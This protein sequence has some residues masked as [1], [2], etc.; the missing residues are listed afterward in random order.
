MKYNWAMMIGFF[1]LNLHK[2]IQSQD[3]TTRV[4]LGKKPDP[5]PTPPWRAAQFQHHAQLRGFLSE[6]HLHDSCN[7]S[8][9]WFFP[10]GK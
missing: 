4:F 6:M 10:Q 8:Y 3:Q 7:L 2:V 1:S 5:P 9:A